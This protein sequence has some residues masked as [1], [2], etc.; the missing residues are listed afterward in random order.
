MRSLLDEAPV[1]H[2]DEEVVVL[3]L[4][5]WNE[6][7]AVA[8]ADVAV[9]VIVSSEVPA[10]VEESTECPSSSGISGTLERLFIAKDLGNVMRSWSLLELERKAVECEVVK[11]RGALL[12]IRVLAAE[13]AGMGASSAGPWPLYSSQKTK[14]PSISCGE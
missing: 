13:S 10:T 14:C 12:R 3:K 11:V 1:V 5:C 2:V 8:V 7:V 4:P 9:D 6:G